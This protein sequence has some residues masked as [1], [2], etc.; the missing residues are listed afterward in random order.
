MTKVIYPQKVGTIMANTHPG[1]YCGQD[2]YN[3]MFIVYRGGYWK[4]QKTL[5]I[6]NGQLHDALSPMNEMSKTLN[7]MDDPMKIMIWIKK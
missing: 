5:C 3:D 2:A 4:I 6:G 7:C 1:S